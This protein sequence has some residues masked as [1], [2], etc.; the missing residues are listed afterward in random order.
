MPFLSGE[1]LTH[2]SSMSSG[3]HHLPFLKIAM[4]FMYTHPK[5][6]PHSQCKARSRGMPS[7]LLELMHMPIS[8]GN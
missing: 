7:T 4:A 1:I 8:A 6:N 2:P 5:E 3:V